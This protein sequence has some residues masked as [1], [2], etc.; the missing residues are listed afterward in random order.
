MDLAR[1][2]LVK[3]LL[4]AR[5]ILA[6]PENDF[7]WSSWED[8]AHAIGE[9]DALLVA[10]QTGELPKRLDIEVLFAPTGPLQ[11]V[12]LSSGWAHPFLTLATRFDKAVEG[13]YGT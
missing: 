4:D 7:S 8:A 5:A 1:E 3:V 2:E 9:L 12:S 6:R 13:V 11:E 10:L